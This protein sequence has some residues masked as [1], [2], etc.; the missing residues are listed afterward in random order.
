MTISPRTVNASDFTN[1]T[2]DPHTMQVN[3]TRYAFDAVTN[4][5]LL[6]SGTHLIGTFG[7]HLSR[8]AHEVALARNASR[9]PP[10]TLD[11][12]WFAN[13]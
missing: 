5:E 11:V 1:V 12:L 9:A 8:L 2:L 6:S 13:P 4:V 10:V 3:I 7:S